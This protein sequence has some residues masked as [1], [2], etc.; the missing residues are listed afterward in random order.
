MGLVEI[1]S[2][3]RMEITQVMVTLTHAET[4]ILVTRPDLRSGI[5]GLGP[6][7]AVSYITL[8]SLQDYHACN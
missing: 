1:N 2:Q 7:H 5:C 6:L 3:K 8:Q 4:L